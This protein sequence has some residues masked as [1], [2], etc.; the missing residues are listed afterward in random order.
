MS[1]R[2]YIHVARGLLDHPRFAPRGAFSDL[3]AWIWLLESAAFRDRDVGVLT[4]TRREI[5]R[6]GPG[7]LTYSVRFLASAWR[8]SPNRVRRFLRDLVNDGSVTTQTDTAQ[9]IVT[10]C[11]WDKYQ[12]LH[13]AADTQTDT[14]SDTK[15]NTNKKTLKTLKKENTGNQE[16]LARF[17]IWWNACPKRVDKI[18]AQKSFFKL[19]ATDEIMFDDL[20][21][22][23]ARWSAKVAATEKQFIKGPAVWLN[24]GGFL[25]EP[26]GQAAAAAQIVSPSDFDPEKWRRC[27]KLYHERA[28]WPETLWGPRPGTPNCLVPANLLIK[29]IS[30]ATGAA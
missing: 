10:I 13:L 24:K 9:T 11:N 16:N 20:M 1:N 19:M 14:Q 12:N 27:L 28:E 4:G 3:E 23:T 2:G 6:L 29:T 30:T 15:S 25:D 21:A 7:Q 8:W 18:A 17:E 22:A 5:V 26:E